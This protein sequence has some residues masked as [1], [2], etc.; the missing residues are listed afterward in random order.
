MQTRQS[1]VMKC[2]Q[3]AR[4]HLELNGEYTHLVIDIT[5]NKTQ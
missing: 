5:P 2:V 3:Y 1:T 4:F